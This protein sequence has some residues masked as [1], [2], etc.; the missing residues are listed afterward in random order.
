[1]GY[2]LAEAAIRRGAKV[3]L[4]S[5][6]ATVNPP[7]GVEF[8][9]VDSTQ[10]MHSAVLRKFKETD[11]V[12]M[13]AA[14]TDFRPIEFKP[15]K[16]KKQANNLTLNLEKNPDIAKTLGATKSHQ[17]LVCFAAETNDVIE[18]AKEKL[19][20][21]NCDLIVANDILAE[22]AGFATD[23]NIVTLLDKAGNCEQLPRLSKLE[24]A[25][26]IFDRIV[27]MMK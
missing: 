6:H 9:H 21:K 8:C 12:V 25:E 19:I 3:H 2:A 7:T 11:I 22:G 14:P 23:T 24:V 13:A 16:I 5:G 27:E 15:H 20:K 1:M 18:N 10:E 26:A 4:V 17:F